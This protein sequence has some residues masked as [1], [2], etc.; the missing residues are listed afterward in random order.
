MK[1]ASI[2][3][4]QINQMTHTPANP[5]LPEAEY[6]MP[7]GDGQ[8]QPLQRPGLVD[9]VNAYMDDSDAGNIKMLGH[10]RWCLNP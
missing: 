6:R 7:A 1:P 5:G 9:S 8:L 4:T 10:R 3:L 2:L